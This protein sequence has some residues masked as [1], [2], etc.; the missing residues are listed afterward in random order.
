MTALALRDRTETG[1]E[2][3]AADG[4]VPLSV[5]DF[6]TLRTEVQQ[7]ISDGWTPLEAARQVLAHFQPDADAQARLIEIGL[8]EQANNDLAGRRDKASRPAVVGTIRPT[9]E[10]DADPEDILAIPMESP[11]GDMKPLTEWRL[12]DWQAWKTVCE[13]Q[14][15]GW[16]KRQEGAEAI[17]VL[18]EKHHAD[19]AADLPAAALQKVRSIVQGFR[20]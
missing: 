18:L 2:S 9:P 3:D 20:V 1:Y 7:V 15:D 16:Y 17:S 12:A 6:A 4:P 10:L 11:T 8:I 14:V 5:V 19:R 13:Q